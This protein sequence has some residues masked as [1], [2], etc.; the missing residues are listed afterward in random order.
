MEGL[1]QNHPYP[2]LVNTGSLGLGFEVASTFGPPFW[3]PENT[4]GQDL[5]AFWVGGQLFL[6]KNVPR[7][8]E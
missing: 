6:N 1:N 7:S 8:I 2:F 5:P 4:Q 3:I